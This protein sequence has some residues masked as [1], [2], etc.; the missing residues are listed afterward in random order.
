MGVEA[1]NRPGVSQLLNE[2]FETCL[3]DFGLARQIRPYDTHVTTDLV[4][5]DMREEQSR[6]AV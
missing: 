3:A 4:G 1:Q 6:K 2:N 5:I